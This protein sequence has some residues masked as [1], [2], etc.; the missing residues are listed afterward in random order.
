MT[1]ARF[2]TA[3][4]DPRARGIEIGSAWRERIGATWEA[5]ERLFAAA[6]ASDELQ[7][8]VGTDSLQRT[9][10]WAPALAAEI[11]G[12][13]TGA[14]LENWQ[15]G[16][17]NARTEVLAGAGATT[18]G[19]CSTF[20]IAPPAGGEPPRTIQ[21]WDWYEHLRDSMLL[22]ELEPRPGHAVHL[23]T[24]LGIVGKIGVSS[25]GLG[26]HFNI[27]HHRADGGPPGVPVHVVARRILD[28]AASVEEAIT[29]ARTA[30]LSAST[31]LTV[32]AWDGERASARCLELS[33]AGLG[34]LAPDPS[35][36]LI[37]T[38][39]FLD[40]RLARG[41]RPTDFDATTRGRLESI[42]NR[43]GRVRAAANPTARAEALADH[44]SGICSH[45]GAGEPPDQRS[46]TLATIA[47]D[48]A[49]ARVLVHPEG[50][51]AVTAGGWTSA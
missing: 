5:Y 40:P 7:R 39:H 51:C 17:L 2:R 45:A 27:L 42:G 22:L 28:E 15:A 43:V 35:C 48:V 46:A 47:L 34:V 12:I 8:A 49:G 9:E 4:T 36:V 3:A 19:E 6:G 21:T 18:L 14:G 41:E 11:D 26:L 50:P 23:F 33:P 32:V 31:V 30:P 29:L 13:A 20:A 38:N 37:H 16:T 10:G 24:E 1:I 25:A 44:E